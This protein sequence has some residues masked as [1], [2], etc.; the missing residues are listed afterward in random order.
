MSCERELRTNSLRE[1]ADPI[2]QASTPASAARRDIGL[3]PPTVAARAW[4]L[5]HLGFAMSCLR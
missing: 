5:W 1:I 4:V 2:K 3:S